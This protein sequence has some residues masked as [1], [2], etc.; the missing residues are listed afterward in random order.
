MKAVFFV[1]LTLFVS[2]NAEYKCAC[3]VFGCTANTTR[4][5]CLDGALQRTFDFTAFEVAENDDGGCSIPCTSERCNDEARQRAIFVL[6]LFLTTAQCKEVSHCFHKDTLIEYQGQMQTLENTTCYVPHVV[7][8]KGY[9][10]QCGSHRVRAT[11]NHMFFTPQGLTLLKD[12]LVGDEMYTNM[13]ETETCVV[14]E[15]GREYGE[16]FGLNCYESQ[17]LAS[18]VK[19][20][21]YEHS[22]YVP[23]TW[24]YVMSRVF[25]LQRASQWGELLL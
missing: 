4:T 19:A 3:S 13:K 9:W 14:T 5:G 23:A 6:D 11:G 1:L 18:G 25:G 16:Y 2:V 8:T 10:V 20:S 17:V 21:L 12:V 15:T 22:H 7:T 24:M